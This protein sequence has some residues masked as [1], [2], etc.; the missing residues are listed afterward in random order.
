MTTIPRFRFALPL[1]ASLLGGCAGGGG[2]PADERVF[3]AAL[4]RFQACDDRLQQ[5]SGMDWLNLR[6]PER[7]SDMTPAHVADPSY[8]DGRSRW[9]M[10][11]YL[12]VGRGCD[13]MLDDDASSPSM[14]GFVQAVRVSRD[15]FWAVGS[16]FAA[17]RLTWGAFNRARAAMER[18]HREDI[19][20]VKRNAIGALPGL[21][22]GYNQGLR[23]APD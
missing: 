9:A 6:S 20:A 14:G 8:P 18:R 12:A 3:N 2:V 11:A 7:L 17:G 23:F 21:E 16:E 10:Q 22:Q 4:S 5:Q 19:E 15:R 1:A 13:R